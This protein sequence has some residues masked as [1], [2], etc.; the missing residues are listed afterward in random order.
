MI[1]LGVVVIIAIS[2]S[3]YWLGKASTHWK[4]EKE[5][6][7]RKE[8]DLIKEKNDLIIGEDPETYAMV[9]SGWAYPGIIVGLNGEIEY[10][11]YEAKKEFAIGDKEGESYSMFSFMKPETVHLHKK[12]LTGDIFDGPTVKKLKNQIGPALSREGWKTYNIEG[13]S[14]GSKRI[15]QIYIP[16][17]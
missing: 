1:A 6:A 5:K 9:V 8:I 17:D 16:H 10:A 12:F 14:T 11:N 7:Y 4:N 15:L 13:W 2:T 3:I